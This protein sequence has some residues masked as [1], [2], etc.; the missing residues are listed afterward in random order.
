MMPDIDG[1][2]AKEIVKIWL[3]VKFKALDFCI[4]HS[5]MIRDNVKLIIWYQKKKKG[6]E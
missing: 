4:V 2:L 3:I 1:M 6:V 5:D